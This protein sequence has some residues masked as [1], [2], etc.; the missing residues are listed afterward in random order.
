MSQS[1][2]RKG[3]NIDIPEYSGLSDTR[4]NLY[5]VR[6]EEILSQLVQDSFQITFNLLRIIRLDWKV[7]EMHGLR[8]KIPGIKT[9]WRRDDCALCIHVYN[10]MSPGRFQLSS[11]LCKVYVELADRQ[12]YLISWSLQAQVTLI[13]SI[14]I[15]PKR[16]TLLQCTPCTYLIQKI[17]SLQHTHHFHCWYLQ[18]V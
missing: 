5:P 1:I 8:Y 6:C 11:M 7:I 10:S 12:E 4:V 17:I 16:R 14:H 18:A 3:I 9:W 2:S 13:I 15:I